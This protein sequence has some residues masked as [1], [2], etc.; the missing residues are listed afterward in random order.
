MERAAQSQSPVGAY[1]IETNNLS[2]VIMLETIAGYTA[3]EPVTIDAIN[4]ALMGYVPTSQLAVANGL[5]TLGSDGKLPVG[6]LPSIAITRVSVVANDTARLAQT[7][8]Y[9]GHATKVLA[10]GKTYWYMGGPIS[11]PSNWELVYD[12]D[13]TYADVLLAE[14]KF[15]VGSNTGYAVEKTASEIKSLLAIATG[16]VSGLSAALSAKADS[17]HNHDS[18]YIAKPAS[19]ANGNVLVW[20]GTAWVAQAPAGDSTKYTLASS[21]TVNSLSWS[22]AM[23]FPLLANK[24]YLVEYSINAW[25]STTNGSAPNFTLMLPSIVTNNGYNYH[26]CH[27]PSNGTSAEFFFATGGFT[28]SP[29]ITNTIQPR[30]LCGSAVVETGNTG[31]NASLAVLIGSVG[32]SWILAKGTTFKIT[33][34]N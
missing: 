27:L 15:M 16:D 28:Q 17:T 21:L 14:N 13:I 9:Y 5:A 31:G 12:V 6:Q 34:L 1:E 30:T 4:A 33:L 11:N 10:T 7:D 29:T 25:A 8:I 18:A 19:P 3:Q 2:G 20:N 24:C 22:S 32:T 26:K 23:Q